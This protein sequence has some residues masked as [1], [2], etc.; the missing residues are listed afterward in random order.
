MN[1][2]FNKIKYIATYL[3]RK[4]TEPAYSM[5]IYIPI[6]NGFE[7][8]TL[9]QQLNWTLASVQLFGQRANEIL[10]VYIGAYKKMLQAVIQSPFKY[11]HVK[12]KS[13]KKVG[14]SVPQRHV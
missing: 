14:T 3:G 2:G 10:V 8:G 1:W 9:R 7:K 11:P 6:K 4:N 13:D 5:D 12:E